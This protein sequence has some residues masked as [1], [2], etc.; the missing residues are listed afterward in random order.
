MDKKEIIGYWT[1]QNANSLII[2]NSFLR[3]GERYIGRQDNDFLDR[4]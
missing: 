2:L 1:R 4:K 3:P